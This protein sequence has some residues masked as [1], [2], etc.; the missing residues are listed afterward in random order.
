MFL[1]QVVTLPCSD[2]ILFRFGL[3]CYFLEEKGQK[4]A[5]ICWYQ[6][7]SQTLLQECAHPNSLFIT[8]ECDDIP[9]ESI[10]SQCNLYKLD[11]S[12]DQ[13]N[14]ASTDTNAFF[15]GYNLI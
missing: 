15:T 11:P 6:H 2:L 13:A 12:D 9:L 1:F 10:Y 4:F 14:F 8:D 3:I 5:H 7:G